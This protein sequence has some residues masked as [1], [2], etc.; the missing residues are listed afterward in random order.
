M[1]AIVLSIALAA[2]GVVLSTAPAA[3]QESTDAQCSECQ[4]CSVCS[5]CPSDPTRVAFTP[6]FHPDPWPPAEGEFAGDMSSWSCK[7]TITCEGTWLRCNAGGSFARKDTD[8]ALLQAALGLSS[9]GA[10]AFMKANPERVEYIPE[11][12]AVQIVGCGGIVRHHYTV[13]VH[14]RVSVALVMLQNQPSFR[15]ARYFDAGVE[16]GPVITSHF[17]APFVAL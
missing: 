4:W 13:P 3:G 6:H 12:Y 5:T 15:L 17:R 9:V 14:R 1:K 7:A 8:K 11:R 16:A 2:S 10:D